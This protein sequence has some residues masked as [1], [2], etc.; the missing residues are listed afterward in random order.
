MSASGANLGIIGQCDLTL[1]LGSK[2][3]TER[4][5]ILQDLHR[6]II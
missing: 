5:I 6:N 2:Q 1:S 4:F 3:F